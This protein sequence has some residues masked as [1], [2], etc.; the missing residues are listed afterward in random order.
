MKIKLTPI[1]VLLVLCANHGRAA[2]QSDLE[3]VLQEFREKSAQIEKVQ[4]KAVVIDTFPNGETSKLIGDVV[5]E[6]DEEDDLFGFSFYSKPDAVPQ[7]FLYDKGLGFVI[8]K[9]EKE[10]KIEKG[11][12]GFLGSPGG[13]LVHEYVFKIDT[14]QIS[15]NLAE[16][17]DRYILTFK[18]KDKPAYDIQNVVRTLELDK[19]DFFPR[20]VTQTMKM[21]GNNVVYST[22]FNDVKLNDD[23]PVGV[24][25]LKNPIQNFELVQ[26]GEEKVNGLIGKKIPD[27]H[28]KVLG[29]S[30]A[31]DLPAG[32]ITLIDFWEV[33]CAPCIKSLPE[34]ENISQ[35]YGDKLLVAGIVTE[36]LANA[37]KLLNRKG[38]SFPNFEGNKDLKELFEIN[39]FPRYLLLDEKGHLQKEY[40]GWSP[41]IEKDIMD[42]IALQK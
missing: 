23:V 42:M 29:S 3:K 2:A 1:I 35:K 27:L 32:K 15:A 9:K 30:K 31:R 16:T 24:R 7:H 6:K 37:E 25:E 5:I 39:S 38:I 20:K 13:R 26:K 36:D 14:N 19:K 18:Y 4:Y 8:S 28:L 17:K 11:D 12:R 22:T 41:E 21:Q 33:W 40:H 10:Y 34:V